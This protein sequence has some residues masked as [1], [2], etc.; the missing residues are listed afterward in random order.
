MTFLSARRELGATATEYVGGVVVAAVVV[1]A[2]A[3]GMSSSAVTEKV[4]C[5]VDSIIEGAGAAC[6]PAGP[7]G[8][9]SSPG[10][11]S[12]DIAAD[13]GDRDEQQR[14]ARDSRRD[15]ARR[16]DGDSSDGGG[17]EGGTPGGTAPTNGLGDPVAGTTP[18]SIP[19]PPEWSSPDQGAGP[20]GSESAE[21]GDHA[22]KLAVEAAANALA[23]TWPDASRNLLHYLG[24][25]G[26]TLD[27]NVDS[28]LDSSK[29]FSA[30][31]DA[32][33]SRVIASAIEQAKGM[34]STGPVTFPVN[35][36]W[37]GADLYDSD[38][39]FYA[40]GSISFNQTGY[41]T[42]TPPAQPGGA[43]TYVWLTQ[44][45]IRDQYNWDGNK[46]TDILGIN[47]TDEQLGVLHR[48]GLAREYT[49]VGASS[50]QFHQGEV[51]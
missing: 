21:A 35:T 12:N 50:S 7:G 46:S 37:R 6:A 24:N 17:G 44:V 15:D 23:F 29:D 9:G 11:A 32:Q 20:Y 18:P 33:R 48:R 25:T 41:V 10:D 3:F 34:A 30:L 45:N 51:P 47:I 40:L 26:E 22:T 27:Q 36:P 5:T 16:G 4:A 28:M 31:V 2:V 38:N 49:A 43:W 8:G 14:D 1:G 39:W 42:V 13:T 19:D